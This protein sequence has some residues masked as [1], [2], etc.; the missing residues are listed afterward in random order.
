[1]S[2][3]YTLTLSKFY[4]FL[5]NNVEILP[6]YPIEMSKLNKGCVICYW[7]VNNYE[8]FG[9]VNQIL[10]SIT[11]LGNALRWQIINLTLKMS[12]LDTCDEISQSVKMMHDHFSIMSKL[13]M[14]ILD[15][16]W[17]C[18]NFTCVEIWHMEMSK[19]YMK[20]S[21]IYMVMSKSYMFH[22]SEIQDVK[23]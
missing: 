7:L 12:K 2:K 1:M 22:N 19:S 11:S 3:S 23:V 17:K 10:G 8:N 4:M 16:R 20:M 15:Q 13:S 21:K 5:A 18:R 6:L 14:K 9:I